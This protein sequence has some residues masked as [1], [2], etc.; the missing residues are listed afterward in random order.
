MYANTEQLISPNCYK[1]TFAASGV[2]IRAILCL[3]QLVIKNLVCQNF[4]GWGTVPI[5]ET[6]GFSRMRIIYFPNLHPWGDQIFSENETFG[7]GG[8]YLL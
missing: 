4:G 8:Q 6:F 5:D 1:S 3:I 2:V 7:P